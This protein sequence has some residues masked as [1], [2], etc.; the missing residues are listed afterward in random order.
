MQQHEPRLGGR[1]ALITGVSRRQGIAFAVARR[2][3]GAGA[4]VFITHHRPHDEQQ[5]WGA[6]DID[7][8]LAALRSIDPTRRVADLG[9]DLADPVAPQKVMREAVAAFGHIDVLACVH[10]R[11][12]GDGP[13]DQMTAEHLDGHFAVNTRSTIL[14]TREFALQHDG[15]RG[16]RVVWFTSGQQL[17]PMQDEIA[18]ATSKAALAGVAASVA[19]GLADRGILLN[20]VNPGP[21]DTG[22]LDEAGGVYTAEQLDELRRM[23]PL[24]R[25]GEPDDPARLVEFLVS[26]DGEWVVGQVLDSEGGFRRWDAP[27]R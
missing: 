10:A 13:L 15:R 6:D 14:L 4:D 1:V 18:Y 9:I 5:P 2:L 23:F 11:S 24:G 26:D 21:V 3:L 27:R 17:G 20:V 7:E 8:V 12:G 16:G 19:D 25:F 22:Y